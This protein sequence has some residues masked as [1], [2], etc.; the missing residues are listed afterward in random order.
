[1]S[2]LTYRTG[3]DTRVDIYWDR[4]DPEDPG[5]AYRVTENDGTQHSGPIDGLDDLCAV[6]RC[7]RPRDDQQPSIHE[8]PTFGG[9]PP[10]DTESVWSW[11][12]DRVLVAMSWRDAEVVTRN[13]W[14]GGR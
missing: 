12:A 2:T 3:N 4:S 10:A 14:A 5:Y 7:Y 13:E 9:R 1:M 6:L 8:L 11:D